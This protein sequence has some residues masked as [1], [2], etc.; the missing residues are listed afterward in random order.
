[1]S[2][3]VMDTRIRGHDITLVTPD[4]IGRRWL[5]IRHP[6]L[7]RG[8]M[9]SVVMDTRIRGYDKK[10]VTPDLMGGLWLPTLS[11]PA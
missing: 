6:R 11:P 4:L 1:M 9:P 2:S 10:L 7:D 8:S 3:A 5:L